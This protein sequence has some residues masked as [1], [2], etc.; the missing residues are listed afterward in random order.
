MGLQRCG[1]AAYVSFSVVVVCS[2]VGLV[3]LAT[4]LSP[5]YAH[6]CRSSVDRPGKDIGVEQ[7]LQAQFSLVGVWCVGVHAGL[8]VCGGEASWNDVYIPGNFISLAT[9]FRV[10]Y[11]LAVVSV[12]ALSG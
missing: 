4:G 5:V 9:S 10:H 7:V 3:S 8:C 12:F 11:L 2:G 1:A 6:E